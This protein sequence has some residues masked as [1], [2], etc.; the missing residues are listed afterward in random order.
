MNASLALPAERVKHL[1][2]LP[3]S[4]VPSLYFYNCYY[5]YQVPLSRCPTKP[6]TMLLL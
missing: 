2:L 4:V 1:Y 3:S 6:H 5:T